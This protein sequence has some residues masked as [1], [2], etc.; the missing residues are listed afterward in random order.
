MLLTNRQEANETAP[1]VF[2]QTALKG[3]ALAMK[4][5]FVVDSGARMM[6]FVLRALSCVAPKLTAKLPQPAAKS[7]SSW[8]SRHGE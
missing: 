6:R 1:S 5:R 7:F 2:W 4:S 3:W 8:W